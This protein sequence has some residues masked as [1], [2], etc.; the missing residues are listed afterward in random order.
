MRLKGLRP[1]PS[2][3]NPTLR[4]NRD[5]GACKMSE[6]FIQVARDPAGFAILTLDRPEKF[7]A[8]SKAMRRQFREQI[9]QLE[10]DVN[11]H[12][13]IITARGKLFTAGLDL[14][15]WVDGEI[16]AGAFDADPVTAMR[17][18]SGPIIGAINGPAITGGFEISVNCDVLIASEAASFKDTHVQVG[19]LPG[20][21]LSARLPRI[22]G[23]TR[24]KRLALTGETLSALQAME[25]GLVTEVVAPD[26]L[27]VAASALARQMLE[28]DLKTLKAYKSLLNSGLDQSLEQ[29]LK[30]ERDTAKHHNTLVTRSE[31]LARLKTKRSL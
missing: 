29:A 28:G 27:I 4:V 17:G 6:A 3:A 15:E 1:F 12:V 25:W 8:L 26:Q 30:A 14:D 10:N 7:N 9:E 22:I 16:A 2:D 23:A 24:A 13:L 5:V 21:G 19:L 31:V 18:F 11:I 20:W